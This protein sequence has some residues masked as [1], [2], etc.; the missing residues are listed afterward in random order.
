MPALKG[1]NSNKNE[2]RHIILYT[3]RKCAKGLLDVIFYD[4]ESI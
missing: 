3:S 1:H 4:Q 2:S